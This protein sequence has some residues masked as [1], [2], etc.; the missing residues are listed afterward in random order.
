MRRSGMMVNLRVA[1]ALW[2]IT[3]VLAGVAALAGIVHREVY[4]GVF[5]EEFIPGA[6]PQDVM[7]AALAVVLFALAIGVREGQVKRQVVA[8]GLLGSLF[9]LYGIFAI[10]RVYNGWYLVYL[11][12]FALSFWSIVASLAGF[13]SAWFPHLSIAPA[14]LRT[15]VAASFAI[16]VAFTGLWIAALV[17]LMRTHDRIDFLYSIYILDL[18]FVMPAFL[19]TAILALRRVPLGILLAPAIMILGFFV[20]FPL[21][22]NELAKPSVG[23]APEV[24]PMVV[25][26]GLSAFMLF[27]GWQHLSK[28]RLARGSDGSPDR[29]EEQESP[30]E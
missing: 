22:L 15:T 17:P 3:A 14:V 2:A 12:I 5:P 19:V 18:A 16:G 7:T 21:G 28:L 30:D 4:A 8:I 6:F 20:I 11:A 10:E 9:Y 24:G 1:R 26:F 13:R 25:S 27:V 23:L 29:D